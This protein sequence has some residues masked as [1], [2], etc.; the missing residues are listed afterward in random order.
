L[1][2]EER[3]SCDFDLDQA[4]DQLQA[5][6]FEY[7]IVHKHEVLNNKGRVPRWVYSYAWDVAPYYE[8]DA[9]IVYTLHDLRATQWCDRR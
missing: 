6:G 2:S 4:I 9:I 7:V 8:D 1:W 3:L 5:D